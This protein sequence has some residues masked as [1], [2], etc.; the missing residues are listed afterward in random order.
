VLVGSRT[1]ALSG[2]RYGAAREA[3]G[4]GPLAPQPAA[5]EAPPTSMNDIS[6][7]PTLT[8]PSPDHKPSAQETYPRTVC[9]PAATVNSPI[10]VPLRVIAGQRLRRLSDRVE[11]PDGARGPRLL[12]PVATARIRRGSEREGP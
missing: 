8:V 12:L 3:V 2:Q 11:V 5:S 7:W 10:G 1:A 9:T 4:A 6:S